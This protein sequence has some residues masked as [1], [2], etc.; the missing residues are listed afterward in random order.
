MLLMQSQ[1]AALRMGLADLTFCRGRTL[2]LDAVAGE[3]P[4]LR[5]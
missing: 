4:R 3:L 5:T 1:P 2:Q